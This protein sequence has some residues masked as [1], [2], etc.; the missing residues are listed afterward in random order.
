MHPTFSSEH[1]RGGAF[2][3]FAWFNIIGAIGCIFWIAAYIL[4]IRQCFTDKSYGLPMVAICMNLAW[5]FLAS[6]VIPNPVPL[7]HL[8]DRVWF[9]VDL[10]IV[11]QMCRW[12]RQFQTIPEVRDNFYSIILGTTVLAG[13]GLYGFYL[14]YHDLLGLMGAFIVNLVMSVTFLFFYFARRNQDRRGLSVS[15]AWCKMLGTLGTAIECHY[16]IGMTQ[17]WLGGLSFLTFLCLSIFLFDCLYIYGVMRA[18]R[19]TVQE[20][21]RRRALALA[22]A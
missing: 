6:W 18:A 15:A 2:D 4:I 7:W 12:G 21:E 3:P 5:E 9:F 22:V 16:V 13:A 8:F 20:P 11:Y 1:V 17:P 14:Q 10:V 19:A